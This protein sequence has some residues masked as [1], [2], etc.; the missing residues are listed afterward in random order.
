[1]YAARNVKPSFNWGLIPAI[2]FTGIDQIIFRGKLPFTLKHKH[3][4][5]ETLQLAKD[6]KKLN[7]QNMMAYTLL[8]K[9]VLFI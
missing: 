2:I 5:H 1:M 9:L 4:D 6:S 8:I 3:A 7:I